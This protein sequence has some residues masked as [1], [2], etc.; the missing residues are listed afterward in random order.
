[1]T[2]V[3]RPGQW[4]LVRP[5]ASHQHVRRGDI[6]AMKTESGEFVLHRFLRS[7]PDDRFL[8]RGDHSGVQD[9]PW[10]WDQLEGVL[11]LARFGQ[12]W[13]RPRRSTGV[14]MAWLSGARP[15][16]FFSPIQQFFG[17][18]CW[19]ATPVL[20]SNRVTGIAHPLRA[21]DSGRWEKQQLGEELAVYDSK[22]GSVH[23]LNR[24]AGII[25][26]ATRE[27]KSPEEVLVLLQAQFPQVDG[28]SLKTDLDRTLDELKTL[29]LLPQ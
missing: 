6:V 3:L 12:D 15:R 22:T 21:D 14:L 1:M 2:P 17:K 19:Q 20:G 26:E 7:L 9:Q 11:L 5:P 27:G 16:R 10:R 29:E 25:W 18:F 13:R 4:V 8:T 23:V 24:V 28:E